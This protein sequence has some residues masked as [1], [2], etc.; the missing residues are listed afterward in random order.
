MSKNFT[1]TGVA[2]ITPFNVK[3][4][5]DYKSLKRIIEHLISNKVEYIVV[6]GTTGETATINKEEKAEIFRFVKENTRT[7]VQLVAGIGGNN[8][9]EVIDTLKT[10]D[11]SGYD[12]VLSVSPYYNKPSQTGIFYHYKEVAANSPLPII[13]YNVPGRTG[14]NMTAETT[15]RIFHEVKNVIGIKEASGNM[16]QCMTII[17]NKPKDMLVISGDDTLTLPFLAIGMDGVISVAAHAN[18][19][20]FG[21]MVRLALAGDFKKAAKIHYELFDMMQAIYLE[22]NPNGIK[23]LMHIKGFC[24]NEMR[25]PVYPVSEGVYNKLKYL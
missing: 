15:L 18:P 2:L 24:E 17:K 6:L 22:G 7:R 14:A 12:A 4:E 25:L 19:K 11:F 1:G 13:L 3:K 20:E 5:V 23:A 16:E 21:D 9:A 10:T 8:T